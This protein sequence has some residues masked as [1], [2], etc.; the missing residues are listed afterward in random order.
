MAVTWADFSWSS[1]LGVQA[2]LGPSSK[3]NATGRTPVVRRSPV[4]SFAGS[5]R[6]G[7][8]GALVWVGLGFGL[9]VGVGGVLG[10]VDSTGCGPPAAWTV[11]SG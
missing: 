11:L 2:G 6:S 9:G 1:T 8:F 3:V 4:G 7:G 10:V 5:G